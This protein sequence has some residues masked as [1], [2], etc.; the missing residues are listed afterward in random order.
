M[1]LAESVMGR[2]ILLVVDFI[3]SK[4]SDVSRQNMFTIFFVDHDP[5]DPRKLHLG[6]STLSHSD[7]RSIGL[8]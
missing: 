5:R 1:A 8:K 6:I 2:L 3:R 4:L 7:D